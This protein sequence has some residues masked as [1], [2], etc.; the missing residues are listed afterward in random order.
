MRIFRT[1][2]DAERGQ[3]LPIMALLAV[4]FIGLLGLAIDGGRLYVA[5]AELSRALDSAAL[6]GGVELPDPNEAEPTAS[7]HPA[8]PLP[9]A[10]V[11]F[12][13]PG[14]RPD[15]R[16]AGTPTT[17][18]AAGNGRGPAFNGGGRAAPPL[19]STSA[20]RESVS[21]G[22][23]KSALMGFTAPPQ[24]RR[25]PGSGPAERS[26]ARSPRPSPAGRCA[27]TPDRGNDQPRTTL[28]D[29][30]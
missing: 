1:L 3:I 2:R 16:L 25:R 15:L 28:L 17:R 10:P 20:G 6:A 27:L 29:R 5:K 13:P 14:Q 24:R 23:S 19:W 7:A 30:R 22:F 4:A 26:G 21:Q 18:P 12:P 9:A 11:H 8:E